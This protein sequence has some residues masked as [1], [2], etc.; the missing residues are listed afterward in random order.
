M[1]PS[2]SKVATS[3][4]FDPLRD[5]HGDGYEAFLR[6]KIVALAAHQLKAAE[7]EVV[8]PQSTAAVRAD[9]SDDL[10][11]ATALV[12]AARFV[13]SGDRHLLALGSFAG[14]GL[15]TPS[16]FLAELAAR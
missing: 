6:Q 1:K 14:V 12:G 13:V 16:M 10:Y 5:V 15:V 4:V 9:P 8:L 7:S 11:I 3:P 2:S